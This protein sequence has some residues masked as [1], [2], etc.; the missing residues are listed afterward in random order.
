MPLAIGALT[1]KGYED[2]FWDGEKV[3]NLDCSICYTSLC[4]F[5]NILNY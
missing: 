5:Q 2:I 4:I 3:L 1:G